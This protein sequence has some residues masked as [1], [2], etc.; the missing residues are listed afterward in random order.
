MP[1]HCDHR[2]G[3]VWIRCAGL[4]RRRA[5]RDKALRRRG[6]G[7]L[8]TTHH[9]REGPHETSRAHARQMTVSLATDLDT[10]EA[11]FPPGSGSRGDGAGRGCG[12]WLGAWAGTSRRGLRTT[13]AVPA[14]RPPA[15]DWQRLLP[16]PR[17]YAQGRGLPGRSPVWVTAKPRQRTRFRPKLTVD[18]R[19]PHPPVRTGCAGPGPTSKTV[20]RGLH[21]P[22]HCDRLVICSP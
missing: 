8:P 10:R 12:G 13:H 14:V 7:V 17:I 6:C 2:V 22:I 20:K 15:P 21:T 16:N 4:S 18:D 1:S 9:G 11:F 19:A 5:G 3:G